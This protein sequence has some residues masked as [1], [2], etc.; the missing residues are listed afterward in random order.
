MP[1]GKPSKESETVWLDLRYWY[2]SIVV[3]QNELIHI[4]GHVN[5]GY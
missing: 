2:V 4:D 1:I 3:N 5:H